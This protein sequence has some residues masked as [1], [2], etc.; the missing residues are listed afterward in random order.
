MSQENVEI[1]RASLDRQL[2]ALTTGATPEATI[3]GMAEIWHPDVE[4][5]A[6][7]ARVPDFDDYYRGSGEVRRFWQEWF[8]AWETLDWTY[9]LIDA[10][11]QVVA[12]LDMSLRGRSTGI[13]L[14]FPKFAWVSTF[15]DG[16][17]VHTKLYMNPAQALEAVGLA[18]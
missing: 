16:L 3:A 10:R 11:E 9:E 7:D 8:A 2:T 13:E 1:W 6:S 15:R 4:L 17:I 5:D 12:L 18:E 14:P